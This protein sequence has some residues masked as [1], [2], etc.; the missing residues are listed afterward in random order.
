M[1]RVFS[2]GLF[3]LCLFILVG[4]G[5]PTKV[6]FVGPP[7]TTMELGGTKYT[8]PTVVSLNRPGKP[9]ESSRSDVLLAVPFRS[10]TVIAE[11]VMETFGYNETDV[12]R[13][14]TNTC[15]IT[16]AEMLKI[17]DGFA[18]VFDGYSASKQPIYKMT[19][20]KKK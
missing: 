14:S 16:D 10:Q 9:G 20:G 6:Q 15:N 13:L 18:V 3:I 1:T 4:C 12:D 11:G 2:V 7:G 5:S 19:V 17:L 8:L